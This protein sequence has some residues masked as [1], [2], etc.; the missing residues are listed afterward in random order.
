MATELHMSCRRRGGSELTNPYSNIYNGFHITFYEKLGNNNALEIRD[1]EN[2]KTG[3]LYSKEDENGDEDDD[4]NLQFRQSA[5]TVCTL[6]LVESKQ[7]TN[8]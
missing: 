5:F 1:L 2:W 4:E 3:Q 8:S 7:S 6:S